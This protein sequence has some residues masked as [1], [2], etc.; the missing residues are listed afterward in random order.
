[1]AGRE[2]AIVTDTHFGIK[3]NSRLFHDYFEKFYRDTFF[4][5]IDKRNIDTL[6]HLGDVFDVRKGID[7]WALDWAKRVFF[8]PLRERG[9]AVSILVGNHDSYYKNTLEINAL[10]LLLSEYENV[11]IY[12]EAKM[13]ELSGVQICMV[14]WLCESN[15]ESFEN[16]LGKSDLKI[17]YCMGHFEIA[18]FY[19]NSMWKCEK[20]IDPNI[21][22]QFG[23]VYSGHFHNKSRQGNIQYLG[24]PYQLYWSDEGATRGFHFLD[25]YDG[26][27]D[28]VANP[29]TLYHKIEYDDTKE[30]D[31]SKYNSG[32]VKI[33]VSKKTRPDYLHSLVGQLT[34][35]G[36]Y[37]VKIIDNQIYTVVDEDIE[38]ESE[39][40]MSAIRHYVDSVETITRKEDVKDIMR[41]LYQEAFV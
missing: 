37:D 25:L 3:K 26:K 19:V 2:V 5:E 22:D 4:P 12:T 16:I 21:F 30:L 36:C 17:K 28:F 41:S 35:Q 11:Y 20:G 14:P 10:E 9:I 23:I 27:L 18:G 39:D 6:L 33:L 32:F 40:T 15:V 1:M 13:L 31:V 8:D 7:Y 38:F 34:Q 24:N 29:N